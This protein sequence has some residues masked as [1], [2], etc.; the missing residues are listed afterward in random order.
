MGITD[1]GGGIGEGLF[2]DRLFTSHLYYVKR[3]KHTTV[4]SHEVNAHPGC[5]IRR[6]TLLIYVYFFIARLTS[7]VHIQYQLFTVQYFS[8]CTAVTSQRI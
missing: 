4:P 5:E 3:C 6:N 1:I 8:Y 2:S 7:N